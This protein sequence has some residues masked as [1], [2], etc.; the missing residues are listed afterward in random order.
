LR[1]G[2]LLQKKALKIP[3]YLNREH[4]PRFPS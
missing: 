3:M 4:G 1:E 2:F